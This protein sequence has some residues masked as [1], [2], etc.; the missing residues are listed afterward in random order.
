MLA[1]VTLYTVV[2]KSTVKC[3]IECGNVHN[4]TVKYSTVCKLVCHIH[5]SSE[6]YIRVCYLVGQ[7]TQQK[8]TTV[9]AGPMTGT[10]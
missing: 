4:S 3:V 7:Y 9:P 1:S 10:G 2:Q 5:S 6:Q 8:V